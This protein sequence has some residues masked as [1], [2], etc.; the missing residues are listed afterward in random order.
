MGGT[1]NSISP[2]TQGV[3]RY[4]TAWVWGGGGWHEGV[5]WG[6]VGAY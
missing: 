6:G 2:H 3:E 4:G 5:A 1:Q